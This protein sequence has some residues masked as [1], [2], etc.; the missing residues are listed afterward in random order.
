MLTFAKRRATSHRLIRHVNVSKT[1]RRRHTVSMT[2]VCC[3]S[4]HLS[5]AWRTTLY[6]SRNI[7][8]ISNMDD[9][10]TRNV[11]FSSMKMRISV[12]W[13]FFYYP[14]ISVS[15]IQMGCWTDGICEGGVF[16][17]QCYTVARITNFSWQTL[18]PKT[19]NAKRTNAKRYTLNV[20]R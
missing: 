1:L 12:A 20:K 15:I 11:A 4:D 8:L 18:N 9:M 3:V 6:R 2:S 7:L 17:Y 5:L 14:V 19:L 16:C 13:S 10:I